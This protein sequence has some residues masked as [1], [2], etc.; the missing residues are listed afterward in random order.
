MK[1]SPF[2][3]KASWIAG[4]LGVV[5]A[6]LAW[7]FPDANNATQNAGVEKVERPVTLIAGPNSTQIGQVNGPV[8]VNNHSADALQDGP[9][10][11]SG[12][13]DAQSGANLAL[14][15][16]GEVD[17]LKRDPYFELPMKHAL[18]GSYSLL[19]KHTESIVLAFSSYD[20]SL[21]CHPCAPFLSFFEFEKRVSGWKMSNQEISA[22]RAGAYGQFWPEW[23]S[24]HVIGDN[25]YG[26]FV[27]DGSVDQGYTGGSTTVFARVGDE[28]RSVLSMITE[29]SSPGGTAWSTIFRSI[30]TSTGLYDIEV[31]RVGRRSEKDLVFIDGSD[32]AKA[33]VA[34]S[35]GKVRPKDLFRF[36]GKEYTRSNLFR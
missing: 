3:E 17:W 31:T 34:E 28:F 26:V 7:F 33:V 30:P 19:Y 9:V 10:D 13:W 18:I 1:I 14:R 23:L 32:E 6:L 5:V 2:L 15:M 11:I 35:D 21:P 36:D 4:I 16:L 24:V 12:K 20:S 25:R 22:V 29:Q 27:Y 8:V